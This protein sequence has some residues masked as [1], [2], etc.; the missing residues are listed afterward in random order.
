M[1]SLEIHPLSELR[2]EAA[3]LLVE[4][5]TRQRAAEP[6][7]P[8]VADVAA[9]LPDEEGFVATRGG[10]VVAY[11]TG[12]V[13]DD[14]A[15]TSIAGAAARDPEAVR[16]LFG[17]LAPTFGVTRFMAFVPASE[18][19]LVDAFFRLSFGRSATLA[20]REPAPAQPVPYGVTVRESRPDDLRAFAEL[21]QMLYALLT[22]PPSYSDLAIPTLEESMAESSDLWDDTGL[23][24]SFVAERDG[25]P[26]GAIIMYR[27]PP[28]D[29]RIGEDTVDLAFAGTSP[30]ARGTG[31]GVALTHHVLTWAHEQGFRAVSTDWRETNL[32]ASRFWPKRGFR[33]TY[34]RLY[35]A[36]P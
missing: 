24:W 33:P 21:D 9:Q 13:K 19:E 11:L 31:A 28:G 22:N 3:A 36:V 15:Y 30:S 1:P 8:E 7:L 12:A 23:F 35:R 14:T 17:A 34:L 32:F 10:E 18:P 29:L 25:Q 26:V 2:G 5:Y 27:R 16:D 6:L 20:V 4:R